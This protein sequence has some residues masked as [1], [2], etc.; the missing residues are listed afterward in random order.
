MST[1]QFLSFI[2]ED[3]TPDE[4][5]GRGQGNA[6]FI[7][8]LIEALLTLKIGQKISIPAKQKGCVQAVLKT[9]KLAEFHIIR[10]TS[11]DKMFVK[12]IRVA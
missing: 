6:F 3:A 8:S 2:I 9:P 4:L 7:D 12:L 11:P 1:K 5:S 10:R